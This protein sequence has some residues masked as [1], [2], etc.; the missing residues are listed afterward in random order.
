MLLQIAQV[1]L[2]NPD[3]EN[4]PWPTSLNLDAQEPT[5]SSSARC[6]LRLRLDFLGSDSVRLGR[7]G[8]VVGLNKLSITKYLLMI[9]DD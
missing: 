8:R 3:P 1:F 4:D 2:V 9:Q 6:G 5:P 7:G